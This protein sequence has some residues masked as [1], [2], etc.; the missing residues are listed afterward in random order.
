[1]VA[2]VVVVVAEVLVVV[3]VAALIVAVV[4]QT[5]MLEQAGAHS[6]APRTGRTPARCP[7]G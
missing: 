1:M 5:Q 6:S 3:V 7:G 4:R 2:A